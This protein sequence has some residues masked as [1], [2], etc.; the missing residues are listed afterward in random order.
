MRNF[1]LHKFKKIAEQFAAVVLVAFVLLICGCATKEYSVDFESAETFEAALNRGENLVGKTVRFTAN[2]LKPQ[3]FFGYNVI[4]GE[5]LNFVSSENPDVQVGD[6]VTVKIT[7][8][9]SMFGSWIIRY[10]KI[11]VSKGTSSGSAFRNSI[12]VI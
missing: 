12:T 10:E 4:S 5:H 2:D 3:S 11:T 6:T 9:D 1:S 7:S 8:I